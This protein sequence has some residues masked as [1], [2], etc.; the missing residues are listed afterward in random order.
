M[1]KPLVSIITPTYN[2]ER[3]IEQCIRSVLSQ[4][5]SNWEM[6]IID[7]GSTDK[8]PEKIEQFKDDRIHYIRQKNVGIWRLHRTY[9]R[10]LKFSEGDFIAILEG[11]DFWPSYKLEKQ[12]KVFKKDEIVLSWGKAAVVNDKGEYLGIIPSNF[13]QFRQPNNNYIKKLLYNNFIPACTVMIRKEAL[14][15]IG[16]FKQ[17]LYLPYVDYPTWL[18]LSLI[19]K[20]YPID[21]ILGYWR[22]HQNQTTWKMPEYMAIGAAKYSLDFFRR[23]PRYIKEQ[24]G[25]EIDDLIKYRISS[26]YLWLGGW[27]L[28]NESWDLAKM[29]FKK[30]MNAGSFFIK[31]KGLIGLICSN[32]KINFII[33]NK[34]F[35]K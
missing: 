28:I 31:L 22:R 10:A 26:A 12:I 20:F 1:E 14:L 9:N 18:E 29:Y 34:Y 13:D 35:I 3:F 21:E 4:T 25:I 23:L 33:K 11:D 24:I 8:T 27:A 30:A 6:I 32:C 17:P 2:H 16:G 15:S 7:D 5:Y 19:G